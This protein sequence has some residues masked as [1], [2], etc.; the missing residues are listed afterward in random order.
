MST[1]IDWP[2]ALRPSSVEWDLVVPQLVGRSAFDGSVESDT[3]GAPRWGFSITTGV[4]KREE[5][6]EWEA[7]IGRLRGAVNRA[8]CWDWR[9]EAPL[10][11]AT[12]TPVVRVAGLGASLQV[13]G[14]TAS[15][16]GILKAG[17][18]MGIN[19]ELKRLS[20]TISSDGSGRATITFEP[21]LRV[22]A[23]VGAPLVLVKPTAIFVMTS[24]PPS[25]KQEGARF[26]SQ[27]LSF[28]EDLRP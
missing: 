21:P 14:W 11:V 12:G 25:W 10:G 1:I 28:Q 6:P 9:R 23:P 18:Y 27:T 20:Q 17:S 26:P 7:F 15:V 3:V 4:M 24:P 22:Q 5:L 2:E 13:E 16:S 19:G 8:R